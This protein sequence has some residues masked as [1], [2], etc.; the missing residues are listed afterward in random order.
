MRTQL[1][2]SLLVITAA[3]FTVACDLDKDAPPCAGAE[4]NDKAGDDDKG[5]D[6]EPE[7]EESGEASGGEASGG[8]ATGAPALPVPEECT[9][10]CACVEAAGG[11]SASCGQTCAAGLA[12]DD[13]NDKAQCEEELAKAGHADCAPDCEVFPDGG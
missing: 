4:C 5:D 8:S 1:L 11:D 3:S 9:D 6:P 2:H 10:V 12:D 13:P 7:G